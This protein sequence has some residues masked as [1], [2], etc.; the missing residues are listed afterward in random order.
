MLV[1][2]SSFPRVSTSVPRGRK[3]CAVNI[4]GNLIGI[5]GI[6][7]GIITSIDGI[8]GIIAGIIGI[9]TGIFAANH[10]QF[11]LIV[12]SSWSLIQ[13]AFCRLTSTHNITG[14]QR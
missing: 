13:T 11:L 14:W 7:A 2:S 12:I 10:R 4:V 5:I 1:V 3:H 6:I 9:I 8:T